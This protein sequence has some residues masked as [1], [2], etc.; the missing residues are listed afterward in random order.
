MIFSPDLVS[1][2]NDSPAV[3]RLG[4]LFLRFSTP[5]Y[6]LCCFNQIYAGALRGSG[7]SRAPMIILLS[8][9]VVF[10][11]VVLFLVSTFLVPYLATVITLTEEMR[12]LTVAM[13]YPMGWIL[14][15]VLLGIY[16]HRVGFSKGKIMED[17]KEKEAG[18]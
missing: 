1:F 12:M 3:I 7:N 5:F 2:F 8:S 4:T 9:F 18:N 15:S 17:S 11:Q 6:L 10:R 14:A 13:A 16:Y